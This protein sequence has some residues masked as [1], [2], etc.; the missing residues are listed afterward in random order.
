MT[1]V[2]PISEQQQQQTGP[3][4]SP[5]EDLPS[6]DDDGR[7]RTTPFPTAGKL[8]PKPQPRLKSPTESSK[9]IPENQSEEGEDDGVPERK[10]STEKRT[11]KKRKKNISKTK[12]SQEENGKGACVTGTS[13]TIQM[14]ISSKPPKLDTRE[15]K[16]KSSSD[17]T[18]D[19]DHL[20]E[21][22]QFESTI[23]TSHDAVGQKALKRSD[24][25]RN[26]KSKKTTDKNP[27]ETVLTEEEHAPQEITVYSPP[28]YQLATNPTDSYAL[29][30]KS[31]CQAQHKT[32]PLSINR[33]LVFSSLPT[34]NNT[35]DDS[36]LYS[37]ITNDTTQS[38]V[39]NPSYSKVALIGASSDH[40]NR[41]QIV[42]EQKHDDDTN[43]KT[44]EE[45]EHQHEENRPLIPQTNL[46]RVQSTT[47]S[48]T[49]ASNKSKE[50]EEEE[51][52][53]ELE[54]IKQRKRLRFRWHLLYTLINNYRLFDLR[55]R[56]QSRLILLHKQR[57][58]LVDEQ[59][60]T[61]M[62]EVS[63]ST[64]RAVGFAEPPAEL[65]LVDFCNLYILL[66]EMFFLKRELAIL[67]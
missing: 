31:Y 13:S 6:E 19:S 24:H 35:N 33:S 64:K 4:V 10:T 5:R 8:I 37:E 25:N 27:Y 17:N 43:G 20:P 63:E 59:Q 41:Q 46:M 58:I 62:M 32:P 9:I 44:Q 7:L 52:K 16:Y 53:R 50:E 45:E 48:T 61:N 11:S 21:S 65:L 47:T 30:S 14:V 66:E 26:E 36:S 60:F 42:E 18:D 67:E 56:V 38:A 22:L 3:P 2:R 15:S 39:S 57:S 28:P 12:T 29:R 1:V 23:L 40:S 34:R 51:N 49:D 54:R 55:K